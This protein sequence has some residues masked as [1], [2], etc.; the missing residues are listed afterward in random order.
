MKHGHRG[1]TLI[2]LLVGIAIVAML[3]VL[4][5]PSVFNMLDSS[6]LKAAASSFSSGIQFARAQAISRNQLVRFRPVV[7]GNLTAGWEVLDAG[8][9]VLQSR[10]QDEGMATRVT[11]AASAGFVA[12]RFNGLGAA[13]FIDGAG[14]AVAVNP[15][16]YTFSSPVAACAP[17]GPIRCLTIRV[18]SAGQTRLCDPASAAGDSRA[19]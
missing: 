2:E 5:M 13:T 1:F 15:A 9:V 14:A 16:V 10:S 19:C 12:V 6:R 11:V 18:S 17:G 4:A 8:G 3:L 7:A